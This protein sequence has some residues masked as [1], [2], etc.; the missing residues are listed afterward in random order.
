[1]SNA[2]RAIVICAILLVFNGCG[3]PKNPEA[4][5]VPRPES[6]RFSFLV[7]KMQGDNPLDGVYVASKD[8]PLTLDL[9]YESVD[10][11][12]E[13]SAGTVTI[14]KFYKGKWVVCDG[15]AFSKPVVENGKSCLSVEL[16]SQRNLKAGDYALQVFFAVDSEPEVP[17]ASALLRI[18]E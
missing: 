3:Q 8:K 17:S 13:L 18:V 9:T 1:M 6:G 7:L 5:A 16:N 15:A 14:S 10:R 2:Y 12:R 4:I 11:N